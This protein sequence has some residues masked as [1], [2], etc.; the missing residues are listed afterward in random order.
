M[1]ALPLLLLLSFL[2]LAGTPAAAAQDLLGPILDRQNG[3]LVEVDLRDPVT[4]LPAALVWDVYLET[5]S[6]DLRPLDLAAKAR[7]HLGSGEIVDTGFSFATSADSAHHPAGV[8][9]LST[10]GKD[11]LTLLGEPPTA[12]LAL[13]LSFHDLGGATER[14]FEWAIPGL[15]ANPPQLVAYVTNAAD[16]SISVIDLQTFSEVARWS[17]A[18]EASHGLALSPDGRTLYAGTGVDGELLGLDTR[19]GSVVRRI[20]ANNNAHG[21]DS[22][23]D[24]R[25]VFMG[26]GGT[27][28]SAHLLRLETSTGTTTP[29]GEGLNPVGHIDASPDGSRL[30]VANLATDT[31]TVLDTTTLEVIRILPVGDGPN[32]SR[33][34][35]DGRYVFV[36]NWNSSDLTII[37]AETL[38]TDRTI[39]V[40]EG[41]HGVAITPDGSEA[42]VT[43]RISNDIAVVGT[44]TLELLERITAGE[45]GNHITFTPD[46]HLALVTNA[47]ANELMVFD[48][49]TRAL[50]ATVPVGGEPHEIALG[51]ARIP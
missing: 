14:R 24:G 51:P 49:R 25:Y 17:I 50:L 30:Y 1:K 10:N 37:D 23:D 13:R 16:G 2:A 34:T 28:D 21:I 45:Y 11:L 38:S 39:E 31:L 9:T 15:A 8:L 18:E 12:P 4:T 43:N 46:G 36:A 48:V 5:H 41:T 7:L 35:P 26:A 6:G 20:A 42:W 22:T 29:L 27:N 33:S 44:S 47:R 3:V 40:G 19:D 32:E